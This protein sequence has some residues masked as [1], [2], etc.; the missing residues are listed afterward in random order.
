[1]IRS[2]LR[3]MVG[4]AA[5]GLLAACGADSTSPDAISPVE[6]SVDVALSTGDA[7]AFDVDVLTGDDAAIGASVA[8]ARLIGGGGPLRAISQN[9]TYNTGS[10]RYECSVTTDQ[11]LSITRSFALFGGG[12][13]QQSY[14]ALTTDSV[15]FQS[16]ITGT[17]VRP[18]F[19]RTVQHA[20]QATLSGLGGTE[21]QRTFNGTGTG[22]VTAQYTGERGSRSYTSTSSDTIASVVFPVPRSP[23]TFPLSGS[24]VHNVAAT[25]TAERGRT[26]S[27]SVSRRV[28]VTF[29]GTAIVPMTVGTLS[30]TL[31]LQTH[32]V[33]CAQQ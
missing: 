4:P 12:E 28:M 2:T 11:G 6:Q 21:T 7:I 15:R 17:V 31:N 8:S 9:C 10:A 30:C 25:Q 33:S 24:I 19:T 18:N 3:K 29:N 23:E 16:S 32:A 14:D 13:P 1:M 20:R 5:L 26:V 27:R 22:S